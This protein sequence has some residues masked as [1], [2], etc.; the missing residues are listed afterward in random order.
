MLNGNS[1]N[2]MPI[3]VEGHDMYLLAIDGNNFEAPRFMAMQ[4]PDGTE[5]QVLLAPAN[6]AEFLIK[7]VSTPGT[8]R[9]IQLAQSQQ[10]LTSAKKVIAELVVKDRPRT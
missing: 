10:F 6:R 8:Y 9:I 4:H 7:A 1:D 2:M 5:P 3:I